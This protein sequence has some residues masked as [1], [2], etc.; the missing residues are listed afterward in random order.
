MENKII[1]FKFWINYWEIEI[2]IEIFFIRVNKILQ[3]ELNL[4][5]NKLLCNI[6]T[7]ISYNLISIE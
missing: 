7:Y 4:G 6:K 5:F 2:L 3:P 1:V